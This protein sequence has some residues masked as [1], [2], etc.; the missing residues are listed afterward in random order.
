MP[1]YEMKSLKLILL[2]IIFILF[3]GN[4]EKVSA[5]AAG[6]SFTRIEGSVHYG[7]V[8]P[9]SDYV[10]HLFRGHFPFFSVSFSGITQGNRDWHHIYNYPDI[11]FDLMYADLGYPEVLGQAYALIPHIKFSLI[12][13]KHYRLNLRNG[14]GLGYLTK[15]FDMTDNYKNSA[16]STHLNMAFN[17]T[18]ESEL[19]F[20]DRYHITVGVGMTHFSNG[21]I[22]RP[23]RGINIP[24][25]KLGMSFGK[26]NTTPVIRHEKVPNDERSHD[27]IVVVSG[28]YSAIYPVGSPRCPRVGLSG[29]LNQPV[30]QK[31]RFGIGY[32]MFYYYNRKDLLS[33][34]DEEKHIPWHFNHGASV[35]F[36]M[37]FSRT[38]FLIQK[39]IY[40]Y[41]KHNYQSNIFYHRAGFRH[42]VYENIL[43]NLTLKTHFFRAQYIEMGVGYKIF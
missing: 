10:V 9:H 42:L 43:L 8:T 27:L 4:Q 40:F 32:D 17:I 36:Q 24:A 11:G 38:A 19:I 30:G 34:L 7:F 12:N 15:K 39:G 6:F 35:V 1:A 13:N 41:D 28:G 14:L 29:M 23:N 20:R 21:R 37:D 2:F 3:A 5:E 33:H 18:M 26:P 25:L 31:F 16:I 22:Q